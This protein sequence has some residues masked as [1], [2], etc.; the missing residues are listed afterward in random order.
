MKLGCADASERT[1]G[2]GT[3]FVLSSPVVAESR[4][5]AQSESKSA[6]LGKLRVLI[7]DDEDVVLLILGEYLAADGHVVEACDRGRDAIEKFQHAPFDVVILDLAMP[8]M[9]G[10]QVAVAVKQLSPHIPIILF[11]GF[12]S[13][14]QASGEPPSGVDLVLSKPVTIAGLRTALAKVIAPH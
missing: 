13:M 10:D 1:A 5:T 14:I 7:A 4:P 9:N 2:K 12:G 6:V 8:D 3:T 11:T